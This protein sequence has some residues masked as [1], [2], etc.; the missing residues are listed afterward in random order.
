MKLN[1]M[2]DEFAD[3]CMLISKPEGYANE[4]SYWKKSIIKHIGDKRH[5]ILE[6]GVGGGSNL[7]H[8]T[9]FFETTAVDLSP[10]M[11]EH[12]KKLNPNTRHFV[13]DMRT[14]RLG[15]KFDAVLIHDAI[16]Y[17]TTLDDLEAAFKTAWEHLKPGGVLITAPDFVKETFKENL[18]DES[19]TESDEKTML[20]Y[21]EYFYDP[22][23]NDTTYEGRYVF[24][25]RD[26][27]TNSL[28]IR[29]DQHIF[30]L[31]QKRIG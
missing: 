31:F 25:I 2:Y 16:T 20:T 11:L 15:E 6:L 18:L 17:M 14:I 12:S 26:L 1:R 27:A 30:G 19:I 5:S 28:K 24:F 13:G 4:A 9:P 29:L 7:S 8:L 23:P 22:D 21:T 10:K 3:L